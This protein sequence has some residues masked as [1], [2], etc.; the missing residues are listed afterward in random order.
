[1]NKKVISLAMAACMTVASLSLS[2]CGEK[3]SGKVSV[4]VGNWPVETSPFYQS[5]EKYKEVFND[6]YPDVELVTDSSD[7]TFK[8]FMTKGMGGQLPGIASL[9]FTEID[10]VSKSGFVLELKDELEKRGYLDALDEKILDTIMTDDGEIYC[11][12]M[13]AYKLGLCINKKMFTEAGL[14]NADGSLKYPKTYEEVTEFSKIIKEKTGKAGIIL[15]TLNN[16]GGW[17]FM[18]IA[19]SHGVQ[20]MKEVDGKWVA[21]FDSEQMQ[22]A[23]QYV[24]DLKWKYNVLP[25][26]Q[27]IDTSEAEKLFASGEGAM[28]F[29]TP[30]EQPLFKTY[31]MNP[32]DV[33]FAPVPEGPA[34]R[35]TLLGGAFYYI[36]GKYNQDQVDALFNWL[37]IRGL[38]PTVDDETIASWERDFEVQLT[39]NQAVP[40]IEPMKIWSSGERAE[41]YQ[42]TLNKYSNVDLQ[43]YESYCNDESVLLRAEEPVCCQELYSIIDAGLQEIL[44]NQNVDIAA[45]AKSMNDSFQKDYLDEQ[46]D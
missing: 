29:T 11:I 44:T 7:S 2:G 41:K 34:G 14:V 1:M 28:F 30:T 19:W 6:K 46:E 27:L 3:D 33:F 20:F 16:Q 37:E 32:N 40:P 15:P 35:Y 42:E 13:N 9:P 36:N 17:L 4:T 23:L 24:Y 43:N 26:N 31:G 25:D 5:F 45:L 18:P 39:N 8:T 21:T 10:K 38:T 22:S 12:P